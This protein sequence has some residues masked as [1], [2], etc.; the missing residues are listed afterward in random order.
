MV[1]EHINSN[2]YSEIDIRCPRCN[3]D[4][5]SVYENSHGYFEIVNCYECGYKKECELKE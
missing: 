4:K 5:I 3:S 1:K 2:F